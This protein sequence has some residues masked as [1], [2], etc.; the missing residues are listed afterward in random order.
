MKFS[1]PSAD[2]YAPGGKDP[3]AGLSS[4]THLGIGAHADD[5]EILAFP[6]IAACFQHPKNRFSGIVVTDG[7][8]APRSGPFAQ[9]SDVELIQL[10]RAEQ[11]R[12]ADLG[13][14]ASVIQLAHPS[15]AV[16]QSDRSAVIGDLVKIFEAAQPQ[17]LY[18]HNPA[19]RHE[20]HIAVL[21]ACI[22]A[23]R[24]LPESSRPKEIYGCEVWGDLDWVPSSH[25]VRLPCPAPETLG[26]SLL[27]CFQSQIAGGKRYDRA[28]LGRRYAQATFGNPNQPD[29]EQEIVLA[30]DLRP[31]LDTNLSLQNFLAPI[32][33]LFRTQTLA[34]IDKLAPSQ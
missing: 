12:A 17:T 6:G 5:L 16:R 34:R 30:L 8:G 14:Y 1:Q 11:R 29:S 24:Q 27:D 22:E 18:L 7:A 21:L 19:D 9:T 32:F 23:L 4:T 25:V 3:W 15:P 13:H 33:D 20:T 31:L 10:R 26:T 2:L 28:A